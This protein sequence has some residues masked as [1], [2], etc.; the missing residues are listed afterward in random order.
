MHQFYT[1]L[2]S[3]QKTRI[4]AETYIDLRTAL[5]PRD[6]RYAS[7]TSNWTGRAVEGVVTT[8]NDGTIVL[9]LW[10]LLLGQ[11]GLMRNY[12]AH[13]RGHHGVLVM[14]N[15]HTNWISPG[16]ASLSFMEL[17]PARRAGEN[18]WRD[19]WGLR[20]PHSCDWRDEDLF[21][22]GKRTKTANT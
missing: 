21:L 5:F 6:Y 14:Q 2:A 11:R 9:A 8:P 4:C 15:S 22:V 19:V 18:V 7:H 3:L 1:M 12:R 16:D 13:I 20:S 17:S 10:D